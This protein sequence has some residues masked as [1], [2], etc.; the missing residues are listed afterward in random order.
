MIRRDPGIGA[1]A[2]IVFPVL[3]RDRVAALDITAVEAEVGE[4]LARNRVVE[5]FRLRKER[6]E[7]AGRLKPHNARA[8][9]WVGDGA[10]GAGVEDLRGIDP[11]FRPVAKDRD[12]TEA[13]GRRSRRLDQAF[14]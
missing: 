13:A 7:A 5:V 6:A 12:L 4:V 11:Q 14:G 8:R 10:Q 3:T 2:G 1:G 9:D